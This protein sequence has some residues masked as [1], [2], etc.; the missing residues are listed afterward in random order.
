[1]FTDTLTITINAVAKVMVRVNQDGYS[2]EYRLK[3]ADGE[4]RLR[5]RNTSYADKARAGK[6]VN[7]HNVELIHTVYPV[8][9]AVYPTIRKTYTVFEDDSG[10]TLATCAKEVVGLLAFQTEANVTKLQNWES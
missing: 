6:L 7:R 1:M 9:P 3:E 2:S 5:L 4:Y 10:D 8:S